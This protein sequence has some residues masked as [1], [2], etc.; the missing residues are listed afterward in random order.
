MTMKIVINECYGGFGLSHE[1]I[2]LYA[3]LKGFKLYTIE[4]RFGCNYYLNE[5][6][7]NDSHFYA[8]N[9]MKRDDPT[10]IMVVERLKE[11]ANGDYA[12]LKVVEIPDGVD[13]TIEEYDGNEHIAES[14]R[15]W[16]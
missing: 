6:C 2:M 15:T 8:R 13:W 7:D 14:H 3:E 10:L 5:K 16:S 9:D 12:K 11:K 4:D 1:A